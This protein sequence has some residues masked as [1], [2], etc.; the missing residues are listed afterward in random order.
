MILARA[1]NL[2]R[3]VGDYG[4]LTGNPLEAAGMVRRIRRD[5]S[6]V[7]T[8]SYRGVP[9]GFRGWDE[10]CV[11]EILVE[12]EYAFLANTL[13]G[14]PRPLVL[15]VGANI[16]LFAVWVVSVAPGARILSVEADPQTA[17]VLA[18]NAAR[19]AGTDWHTINAAA[20]ATDGDILRLSTDGPPMSHRISDSGGIEVQGLSLATLIAQRSPNGEPIDLLKIDIEGS[21]ERFLCTE[22]EALANV[23]ELV[24]ELHPYFCDTDRVRE[25]VARHFSSVEEISGRASSK[26]LLYCRK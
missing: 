10:G 1:R 18:D 19:V 2:L 8:L 7:Q 22:P 21:E 20:A 6:E 24:V 23:R 12:L 26:P 11:R 3:R 17:G 15:D 13:M 4:R 16:G 14:R 25:T 9:F 5:A